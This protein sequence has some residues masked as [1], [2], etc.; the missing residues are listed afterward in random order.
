MLYL[1]PSGVGAPVVHR[2][3]V[4]SYDCVCDSSVDG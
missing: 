1:F 3:M 4:E 2:L